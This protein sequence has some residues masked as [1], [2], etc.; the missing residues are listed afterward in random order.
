MYIQLVYDYFNIILTFFRKSICFV[1]ISIDKL[2]KFKQSAY[3]EKSIDNH[4][5]INAFVVLSG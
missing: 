2:T 1:V 5:I 4:W 3:K